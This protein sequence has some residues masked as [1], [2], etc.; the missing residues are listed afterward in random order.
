MSVWRLQSSGSASDEVSEEWEDLDDA[1]EPDLFFRL[2][3]FGEVGVGRSERPSS[4]A[5]SAQIASSTAWSL[6]THEMFSSSKTSCDYGDISFVRQTESKLAY[7]VQTSVTCLHRDFQGSQFDGS[8]RII[9]GIF[10]GRR[11]N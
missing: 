3:F 5:V 10:Q 7:I 6:A 11:W 9:Y 2:D 1:P 4:F 8:M